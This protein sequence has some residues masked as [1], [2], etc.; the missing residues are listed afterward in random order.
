MTF[1]VILACLFTMILAIHILERIAKN[2][3]ILSNEIMVLFDIVIVLGYPLI[4]L[5]TFDFGNNN[6]CCGDTA[7]FSPNHRLSIYVLI[8]ICIV[9]YFYSRNTKFKTPIIELF[10]ITL[11]TLGIFLN[12]IIAIH[13]DPIFWCFNL[14]ILILFSLAL[15]EKNEKIISYME[16]RRQNS[17]PFSFIWKILHLNL[18]KKLPILTLLCLPL[19]CVFSLILLL[20][21]Q[22]PDSIIS[23]FTQ[24]YY[25]RFS[26]L[27]FLCE[28][29]Q[30]GG[31]YLC[32][33][34][35]NGHTNIVKP[36]RFGERMGKPIICNRQLLVAN[37]FEELIQEKTPRIHYQ[38]RK[39]Y[40]RIGHIIH[41][42]YSI[43]RI[44]YVSD[45]IYILMKPLEWLFVIVLYSF[46]RNPENRIEIQYVNKNHRQLFLKETAYNTGYKT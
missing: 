44:K 23:A 37:A 11:L 8:V 14:Q 36:I 19:L 38:I 4:F 9:N 41:R 32:S 40:N 34:A 29:V 39:N 2:K 46:D 26:Q 15:I 30:C 24:T 21:G 7:I 28:N 42:Y 20:F 13:I 27:D 1:L 17:P 6:E 31:H 22:R 43:F 16:N 10:S 33:V 35:A 18:L 3:T 5:T 12:A 45:I 25:Q